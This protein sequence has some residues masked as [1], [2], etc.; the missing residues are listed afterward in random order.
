MSSEKDIGDVEDILSE[1]VEDGVLSQNTLEVINVDDT[2]LEGIDGTDIDNIIATDV[3]LMTVIIDDSGSIDGANLTKSIIIGQNTMMTSLEN[4]KQK[5][6]ILI[7][8]WKLGNNAELLHSYLPVEQAVRLDKVNYNPQHSTALYDVW[9]DALASNVA[10]AQQ[11]KSAGT[12]VKSIVV[13]ITDG[14]DNSS[15]KYRIGDCKKINT[16]LLQSEQFILAFVGAGRDKADEDLFREIAKDM[17]FPDGA[18]LTINA[19]A[20]EIRKVFNV[21]SQSAIRASQKA[22]SIA[23]QNSFFDSN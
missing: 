21:I 14:Q 2:V 9:I 7:A 19:T 18:V 4:S 22:V 1:A 11:L 16:D 10:Y 23:A 12:P 13:V 17:G 20:S 8:Q 6:N 15:R 3:T 5:D